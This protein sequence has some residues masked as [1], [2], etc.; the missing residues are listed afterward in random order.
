MQ[1]DNDLIEGKIDIIEK[2]LEFLEQYKNKNINEFIKSYKDIQAAKF[3]LFEII[4]S[5]LDIA[6]HIISTKGFERADNYSEMFEILGKHDI[7]DIG[8]SENL[9]DMARFRN[10]LI[11]RYN[12]VDN[13]KIFLYIKEELLYI[14]NF[15]K[16]VLK[17]IEQESI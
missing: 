7:I 8:L 13:S 10:L 3:S 1:V 12:K 2:N 11:H 16:S 15:I 4:E 5:C 17:L 6:S 14:K 9:S